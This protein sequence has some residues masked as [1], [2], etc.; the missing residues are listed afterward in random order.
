M[1]HFPGVMFDSTRHCHTTRPFPS[2]SFGTKPLA[3]E[4]PDM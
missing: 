1:G 4:G 3:L 2:A